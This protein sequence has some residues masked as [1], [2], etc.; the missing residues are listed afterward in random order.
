MVVVIKCRRRE[1]DLFVMR[2]RNCS[3]NAPRNLCGIVT[4]DEPVSYWP[5]FFLSPLT[6]PK[7]FA[8]LAKVPYRF[9]SGDYGC[10]DVI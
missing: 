8:N 3:R 7:V 4:G 2:E 9:L 6:V 5:I 10:H 1:N